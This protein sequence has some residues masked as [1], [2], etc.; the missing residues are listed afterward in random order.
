MN[1]RSNATVD[2]ALVDACRTLAWEHE[3]SSETIVN[4][5]SLLDQLVQQVRSV[6]DWAKDRIRQRVVALRKQSKMFKLS[7]L[8]AEK[9]GQKQLQEPVQHSS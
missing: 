1:I 7:D 5:D 8:L 6:C 2:K 4:T 9:Y 3:V